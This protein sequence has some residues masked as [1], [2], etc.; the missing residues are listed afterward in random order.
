MNY[1]PVDVNETGMNIEVGKNESIKRMMTLTFRKGKGKGL[2][3]QNK[4]GGRGLVPFP[5]FVK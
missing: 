4:G 5:F 1:K 2:L 3:D